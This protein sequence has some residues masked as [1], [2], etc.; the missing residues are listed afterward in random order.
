VREQ[1]VALGFV[2]A[3]PLRVAP[4]GGSGRSAAGPVGIAHQMGSSIG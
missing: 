3:M 2:D 4:G 1:F